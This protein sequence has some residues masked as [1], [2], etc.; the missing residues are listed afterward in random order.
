[1]TVG[2]ARFAGGGIGGV[3]PARVR[4]LL[5]PPESDIEYP[6]PVGYRG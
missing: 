4:R 5:L 6:V 3:D 2:S 1:M